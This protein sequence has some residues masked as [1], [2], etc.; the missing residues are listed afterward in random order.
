MA[1]RRCLVIENDVRG[2][3]ESRESGKDVHSSSPTPTVPQRVS[4][5]DSRLGA[6]WGVGLVC[7]AFPPTP[8]VL[9]PTHPRWEGIF[10]LTPEGSF[11][12]V[13]QLSRPPAARL[14]KAFSQL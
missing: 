7:P 10:F 9:C 13:T 11:L 8:A 5:P 2:R 12:N 6:G 1:L 14:C 3:G 4:F